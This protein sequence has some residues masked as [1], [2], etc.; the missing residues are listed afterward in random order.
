MTMQ[1]QARMHDEA[2]SIIRCPCET[3]EMHV[4]VGNGVDA[5]AVVEAWSL[6]LLECIVLAATMMTTS[7]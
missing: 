3:W 7:G 2:V 5:E 1:L 6:H 4:T